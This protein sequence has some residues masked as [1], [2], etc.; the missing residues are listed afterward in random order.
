MW[1][2]RRV[3]R[4]KYTKKTRHLHKM[5]TPPSPGSSLPPPTSL[6]EPLLQN[7]TKTCVLNGRSG[8]VLLCRGGFMGIPARPRG[9]PLNTGST[10][11]LL[12]HRAAM[13]TST[14]ATAPPS[15]GADS[16]P[17]QWIPV[18][19]HW[20]QKKKA[21]NINLNNVHLIIMLKCLVY[22]KNHIN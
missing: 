13:W 15:G 20:S 16:D 5:N 2:T 19:T 21:L 14:T 3:F 8:S 7:W 22:W 18:R 10:L 9:R 6:V 11:Q 1:K 4:K 17:E 12:D